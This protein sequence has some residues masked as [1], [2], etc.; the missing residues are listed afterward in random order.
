MRSMSSPRKA[1]MDLINSGPPLI[2]ADDKI[3]SQQYKDAMLNL[4]NRTQYA[5][6]CVSLAWLD[7][8]TQLRSR[9]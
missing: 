4:M 3:Y 8:R 6:H 5:V 7:T 9:G 1:S 2:I